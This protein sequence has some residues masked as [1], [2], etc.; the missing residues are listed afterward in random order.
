MIGPTVDWLQ[1]NFKAKEVPKHVKEHRFWSMLEEKEQR[2][3]VAKQ[4]AQQKLDSVNA[5]FEKS[6]GRVAGA[7]TVAMQPFVGTIE[8]NIMCKYIQVYC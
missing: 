8:D 5:G 7:M 4:K 6:L 2:R 1:V 3:A